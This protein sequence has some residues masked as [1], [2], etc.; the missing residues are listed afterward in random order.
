VQQEVKRK[1]N[2]QAVARHSARAKG[3]AT[4][5]PLTREK[6][7]QKRDLIIFLYVLRISFF[8]FDQKVKPF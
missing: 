5:P 8:L 3:E 6:K 1:R 4:E 2:C 7:S